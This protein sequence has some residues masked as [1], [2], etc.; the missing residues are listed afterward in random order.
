MANNEL[1]FSFSF[2][3]STKLAYLGI[4]WQF[5]GGSY[6]FSH[7]FT[8]NVTS[9]PNCWK[10]C[11]INYANLL[12]LPKIGVFLSQNYNLTANTSICYS[13]N[14][15]LE[16]RPCHSHN[17]RQHSAIC[18]EIQK[19]R[20]RFCGIWDV[21]RGT[22]EISVG[23]EICFWICARGKMCAAH[24]LNA[25]GVVGQLLVQHLLKSVNWG[26]W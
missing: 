12:E 2:F 24:W 13:I 20:S 16:K 17:L 14:Q 21:G 5:G 9:R 4:S 19:S 25:E 11:K 1:V 8:R 3:C 26:L 23:S 15:H 10:N 6:I 18:K 7:V 22:T